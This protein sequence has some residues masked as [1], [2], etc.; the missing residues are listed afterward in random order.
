MRHMAWL[1][2]MW[3]TVAIADE[4]HVSYI[5]PAGGQ[6]GTVQKVSVGG[7]NL[8]AEATFVMSADDVLGP[9]IIR[10]AP[11]TLWFEGPRIPMPASQRKEDYP[12]DYAAEL[13]ISP[14]ASLGIRRWR[15]A[16]AQGVTASRPFIVGDLPEYVENEMD[17]APV[18]VAVQ[19]PVTINGRVFPRED[20]DIWT[21]QAEEGVAYGC[22]V[23][24]ARLASPL[25]ARISVLG[26]AGNV[27]AECEDFFGNDPYLRFVA[28]R[29]GRYQVKLHDAKFQGL[30]DYVYRL[31]I[32]PESADAAPLLSSASNPS[33][34]VYTEENGEQT[35][36]LPA[37]VSGCISRGGEIDRW[38]IRVQEAGEWMFEVQAARQ[39][40]PLDAVLILV[41]S[42]G[43]T[44]AEADDQANTIDPLLR[45]TFKEPGLYWIELKD[46]FERRGGERFAYRLE[47]QNQMQP[48]FRVTLPA[49][50]LTVPVGGEV[51][52]K[53]K[54]ERL[55]GFE[56][57]IRVE[58]AD[59]PVG[60]RVAEATV[61][62]KKNDVQLT[63]QAEAGAAIGT[64]PLQLVG[65]FEGAEGESPLRVPVRAAVTDQQ[66][67]T[68]D[69][70]LAV[71]LPTPFKVV[72]IFETKYAAQ[73]ETYVRHYQIERGGF[74]GPIRVKMADRQVRHL[75]GVVGQEVIVPPGE[76]EFDY[77][78][79]LA[80]WMEIGRTSRT[81]VMAV[82]EV[83]DPAGQPHTVSYTSHQQN[84]QIILL[85]DP[86]QVALKVSPETI[87]VDG[88][89][90][91]A[92]KV[93]VQ[94]GQDITGPVR[95][96]LVAPDHLATFQ[97]E[98]VQLAGSGEATLTI[99]NGASAPANVNMPLKVR[100]TA[101]KHG[102]PYVAET[103]L[104]LVRPYDPSD[105]KTRRSAGV[106]SAV[107]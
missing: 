93:N 31:T 81:C 95:V 99:A 64:K 72:G 82:A 12:R 14:Q 77:A 55:H 32:R 69:I 107:R 62:K 75:Q 29:T 24:A 23:M 58:A 56:G 86:S 89:Q 3:S 53:A 26:P 15:V 60:V 47:M 91:F 9:T 102:R 13:E 74:E 92:V 27:V 90:P 104:R 18:P 17:G 103:N 68:H 39:D 83:K 73:G 10:R 8:H 50:A 7:H 40:S 38:Q 54:V 84:D 33:R 79:Q 34:T 51:K 20:V 2:L 59:L 11:K 28:P 101:R 45:H 105:P 19:V 97:A 42:K 5:F 85:V 61:A 70:H 43:Q 52:I 66:R 88:S 21:F 96:E 25:D 106:S 41:D 100:A 44:L 80:P 46:R 48:T 78:I 4:P 57:E 36:G 71:A 98:P 30:Q 6:R 37:V 76:S 63:I 35:I 49:D 16:T 94:L 65:V 22:E 87:L 1:V 67:W